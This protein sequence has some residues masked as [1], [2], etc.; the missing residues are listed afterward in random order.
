IP[1]IRYKKTLNRFKFDQF[2]VYNQLTNRRTDSLRNGGYNWYGEF[3]PKTGTIGESRSQSLS[4]INTTIFTSR[5]NINYTVSDHHQLEANVVYTSSERDGHDPIGPRLSG[6]DID[7]L[8]L[9]STYS[10]LAGSLGLKSSFFDGKFEQQ[11]IAKYFRYDANG[12][13]TYNGRG[14]ELSDNKSTSGDYYGV[15]G[16]WKYRLADRNLLRASV[17]Y[18]Y[19]LP[20]FDELF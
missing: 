11:L 9:P 17:E 20:D 12:F 3:I 4:R 13:E 5:T 8:T 19:R 16:A 18:A 1:S 6:T 15:A 14:V 10:K 2:V 7:V